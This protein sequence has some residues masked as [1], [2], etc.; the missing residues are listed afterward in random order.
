MKENDN[1][2]LAA[3]ITDKIFLFYSLL[4]PVCMI[5]AFIGVIYGIYGLI[6]G[7]NWQ[8][9]QMNL[10]M[11]VSLGALLLSFLYVLAIAWFCDYIPDKETHIRFYGTAMIPMLT[12][13]ELFGMYLFFSFL[14]E[15]LR[16]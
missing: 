16:N 14:Q 6:C 15:T 9:N 4:Q 13:F 2:E 10:A 7:R 11:V 8:F 5:L 1:V 3:T 12:M